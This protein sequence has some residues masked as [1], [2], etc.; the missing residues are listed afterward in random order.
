MA[1]RIDSRRV[2]IVL[3]ENSGSIEGER[4]GGES[5]TLGAVRNRP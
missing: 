4:G 5:D 3:M 2:E 1:L